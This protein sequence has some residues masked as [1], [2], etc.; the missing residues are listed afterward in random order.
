MSTLE[1]RSSSFESAT[2]N[3]PNY[4][5]TS[6]DLSAPLPYGVT[7]VTDLGRDTLGNEGWTYFATSEECVAHLRSKPNAIM[8]MLKQ[9]KRP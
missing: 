2:S 4:F 7:W 3:G 9:G 6:H 5:I 8:L 1:Q